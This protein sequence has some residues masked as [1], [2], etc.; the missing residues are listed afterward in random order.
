M[1]RFFRIVVIVCLSATSA[2]AAECD[3]VTG[4]SEI[5]LVLWSTNDCGFCTRWKSSSGGKGELLNW[6]DYNKIAYREVD[7][8]FR[9]LSL[10]AEHF[11]ADLKWLFDRRARSGELRVGPVPSW[12]IYVDKKE[13]EQSIGIDKWGTIIFPLL[14]ELVAERSA[15]Q[16][17]S[18][19]PGKNVPGN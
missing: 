19:A 3:E 5:L 8:P 17:Q 13:V 1:Q 4:S 15:L 7:R 14:K 11:P 6:P 10:A 18:I 16:Q 2:M 12:T 9:S